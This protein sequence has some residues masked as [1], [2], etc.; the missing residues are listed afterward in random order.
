MVKRTHDELIEGLKH[1]G[2]ELWMTAETA[3]LLPHVRDGFVRNALLESML[4][5]IRS[6]ADRPSSRSR[7]R[8]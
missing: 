5:H 1:V 4:L 3:A 8:R 2:Y 6:L 7:R